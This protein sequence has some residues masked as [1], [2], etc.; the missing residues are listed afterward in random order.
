MLR[1]RGHVCAGLGAVP[2]SDP[3]SLQTLPLEIL[4]FGKGGEE[5]VG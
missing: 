1:S 4:R 5:A 2:G 3:V